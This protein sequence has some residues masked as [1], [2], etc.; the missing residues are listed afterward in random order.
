E[1][2]AIIEWQTTNKIPVAKHCNN[3]WFVQTERRKGD[4]QRWRVMHN[5]SLQS[6]LPLIIIV[7]SPNEENGDIKYKVVSD[8]IYSNSVNDENPKP[9]L[10]YKE[11]SVITYRELKQKLEALAN[12]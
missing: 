1:P 6:Q 2:R 3:T 4:E 11:K 12:S 8:I 9:G 7:W 5:I 10:I